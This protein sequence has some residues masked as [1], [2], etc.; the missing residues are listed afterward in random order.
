MRLRYIIYNGKRHTK[1]DKL[2][3]LAEKIRKNNLKVSFLF[4]LL[5]IVL[6]I[7]IKICNTNYALQI[8]SI[9]GFLSIPY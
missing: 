6:K 2:K 8:I 7:T 1:K 9:A 3:Q 5:Y 4:Y